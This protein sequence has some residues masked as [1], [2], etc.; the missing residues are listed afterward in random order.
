MPH[1]LFRFPEKEGKFLPSCWNSNTFYSPHTRSALVSFSTSI[2]RLDFLFSRRKGEVLVKL[3]AP[4]EKKWHPEVRKTLRNLAETLK[5]EGWEIISTTLSEKIEEKLPEKWRD[6]RAVFEQGGIHKIF[7]PPF[8]LEIGF[9]HGEFLAYLAEKNPH[10]TIVGVEHS[11]ECIRIASRKC[12]NFPNVVLFRLGG[13]K[14][15]HALFPPESLEEVYALFP[16]PWEKSRHQKRRLVNS[17][18]L[19]VLQ[20]RLKRGGKF[21]FCTDSSS[22]FQYTEQLFHRQKGWKVEKPRRF[23]LFSTRYARKWGKMGREVWTLQVKKT[24]SRKLPFPEL[25]YCSFQYFFPEEFAEFQRI[26]REDFSQFTSEHLVLKELFEGEGSF[27][28]SAIIKGKKG[29]VPLLLRFTSVERGTDCQIYNPLPLLVGTEEE[30]MLMEWAQ[31][32]ERELFARKL[33]RIWEILS[34]SL[35]KQNWWPYD[36]NYHKQEGTRPEEEIVLGAIL[37]QNTS[38]RSVEKSLE[39]LKRKKLLSFEALKKASEKTLEEIFRPTRFGRSKAHTVKEWIRWFERRIKGKFSL[40]ESGLIKEVRKEMLKVRGIGEE[41]ADSILLY[42]FGYPE[43][44]I[45][46][47]TRRICS[48]LGLFHPIRRNVE[49]KEIFERAFGKNEE[50]VEIYR[51]LHA[52]LVELGKRFCHKK[53]PECFACVVQQEC[54]TGRGVDRTRN[55]VK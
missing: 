16:D 39:Q 41:T 46:E 14:A 53:R 2:G 9:G 8:F 10:A 31:G 51:E 38:W 42:A 49:W 25:H 15:L 27:L 11:I 34:R 17:D 3:Y 33:P 52:L 45:D 44:V 54:F 37:T 26:F 47:Y 29:G 28:C 55:E 48:R 43:M 19:R 13:E 6:W 22:Y 7:P 23:P 50:K 30:H 1:C 4:V 12:R 36:E 18:F 5:Q 32:V 35:G 40:P 24:Q 21:F 20:S